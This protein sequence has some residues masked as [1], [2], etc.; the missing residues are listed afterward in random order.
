MKCA[1]AKS[2]FLQADA[3]IGAT[4]LF[5]LFAKGVPEVA[6]ALGLQPGNAMEVVGAFYGLTNAPTGPE[7]LAIREELKNLRRCMCGAHGGK[8]RLPLQL[9][10]WRSNS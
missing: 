5:R 4:R 8:D 2:A 9:Q 1:D 6:R 3:D 10:G 7:W